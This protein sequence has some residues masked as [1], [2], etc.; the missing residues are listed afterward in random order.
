MKQ[1][2]GLSS[3]F[4]GLIILS[5]SANA[6]VGAVDMGD[7]PMGEVLDIGM[8]PEGLGVEPSPFD[9]S[10]G[11]AV[12]VAGYRN[13][14]SHRRHRHNRDSYR[15]TRY[16]EP[17]HHAPESH[18]H[19]PKQHHHKPKQ[20][21]RNPWSHH[22]HRHHKPRHFHKLVYVCFKHRYAVLLPKNIARK[23]VRS[24]LYSWGMCEGSPH[25]PRS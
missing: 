5:G 4:C 22:R 6:S 21:H 2:L 16:E 13:F 18:H 12:E 25:R 7:L 14:R 8:M 1:K 3:L 19:K 15:R 20:H 10:N 23:V 24:R 17:R 9:M 11:D